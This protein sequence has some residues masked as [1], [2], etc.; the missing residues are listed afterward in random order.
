VGKPG[1]RARD[2]NAQSAGFGGLLCE[3]IHEHVVFTS[4][5][6]K[7]KNI[8]AALMDLQLGKI[9]SGL[10]RLGAVTRR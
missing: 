8:E 4:K 9:E 2:E 6:Q 5:I 1:S 7:I 3:T 10:V